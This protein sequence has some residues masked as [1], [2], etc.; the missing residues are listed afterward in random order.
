M[1]CCKYYQNV[2]NNPYF[3]SC[4]PECLSSFDVL[5]RLLTKISANTSRLLFVTTALF[6]RQLYAMN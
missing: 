1:Y 6:L 3:R 4:L 5:C 2:R